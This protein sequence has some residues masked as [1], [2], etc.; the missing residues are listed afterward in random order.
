[1]LKRRSQSTDITPLVNSAVEKLQ[2]LGQH[3]KASRHGVEP[4]DSSG[5]DVVIKALKDLEAER[6]KIHE[7]LETET[8]TASVL[9]YKLQYFP[10]DIKSEIQAAVYSARQSNEAEIKRLKTQL[11]TI[12]KNIKSLQDRHQD[13]AK[14]NAKLEPERNDMQAGH[15]EII[16][17]LNQKMADKASKQITLNETRDKLRETYKKI[18]E[19]EDSIVQLKEDLVHEREEARQEKEKLK[20]SVA[21]TQ[22][23]AEEQRLTNIEKRKEIDK[24]QE[25]LVDSESILDSKRKIIRKFETSRNRL[26]AQEVQLNRQL[27][28]EIKDNSVLTQEGMKIV[29][30]HNDMAESLEQ[31]KR[32]LIA[33]LEM[34]QGNLKEAEEQDKQLTFEKKSLEKEHEVALE[35]MEQDAEVVRQHE[36]ILTKAKQSLHH[37]NEQCAKVRSENMELEEEMN[38]LEESHKAT[39]D[40]YNKDIETSKTALT[41][42]RKDRQILQTKRDNV[43]KESNE[44]KGEYGRYMATMSK[45]V[46]EGKAEHAKLTEYG[47]QLQKDL[48]KDEADIISKQKQLKKAKQD[49]TS[50]QK[51]LKTQLKGLQESIDKLEKD[52]D[53]KKDIIQDKTPIFKDLEAQFK[54]Q[55]QE[56][57][58]T[59]KSIVDLKNKK[60]SLETSV[61][62]AQRDVEKLAEPQTRL[63]GKLRERRVEALDQLK[64]Q[65]EDVKKIET[66]IFTSGQRLGAVLKENHRFKQAIR[67][68]E[69]EIETTGKT[70]IANAG[71]REVL[72]KQLLEYRG[73]L[74]E[75]WKEDLLLDKIYA[76]RDSLML[77]DIERLKAET[78]VREERIDEIH[79]QLEEQLSVLS[80]FIDGVANLRPKDTGQSERKSE[81]KNKAKSGV[82]T[83]RSPPLSPK[84]PGSPT[85]RES[86]SDVTAPSG[87]DLSN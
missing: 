86:T 62:R 31:K 35:L 14:E 40:V 36:R 80:H 46:T 70:M 15:D 61:Q 27:Q 73:H 49:Y 42:E 81:E 10:S 41:A 45:K 30:E 7:L 76:E 29:K 59:K 47:T 83:H 50:L 23:K 51:Q 54:E 63:H 58:T 26:E 12:I 3:V 17:L 8:I 67:E 85:R 5:V 71:T 1:M 55:T 28:K 60:A 87:G 24:L 84:P 57:E 56:F 19:L 11:N 69:V 66:A 77:E 43:T 22:K 72:E 68:L 53:K 13:L 64:N 48:K 20:Q 18:I 44:F 25:E 39:V 82:S 16:A 75:N 79:Q 52:R 2:E 74:H 38:Q 78:S 21:D 34:L 4:A 65:S 9:R 33:Q 6:L 32:S 37:Q